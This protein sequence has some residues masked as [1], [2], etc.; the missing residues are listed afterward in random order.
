MK[1][2]QS[3]NK[4]AARRE[5][6][7]L[8]VISFYMTPCI[9]SSSVIQR[10]R[11]LRK[12]LIWRLGE[13]NTSFSV[14]LTMQTWA[15]MLF[16]A[17]YINTSMCCRHMPRWGEK[18]SEKKKTCFVP[19][20]R[21]MTPEMWHYLFQAAWKKKKISKKKKKNVKTI[22]IKSQRRTDLMWS[23]SA[24]NKSWCCFSFFS[25]LLLFFFF[26]FLLAKNTQRTD[27]RITSWNDELDSATTKKPPRPTKKKKSREGYLT[28]QSMLR[29]FSNTVQQQSFYCAPVCAALFNSPPSNPHLYELKTLLQRVRKKKKA[30]DRAARYRVL[31]RVRRFPL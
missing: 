11:P 27:S 12:T 5:S 13:H 16:E 21:H 28:W 8:H 10:R 23:C 22:Y 30:K 3:E 17:I 4:T 2:I 15:V 6:G 29:Q 1:V 26:F 9:I 7:A 19:N 31:W 20:W 18:S 14:F 25:L 24:E